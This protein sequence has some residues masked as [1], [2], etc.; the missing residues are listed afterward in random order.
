MLKRLCFLIFHILVVNAANSIYPHDHW[1]YSK[2]LTESNFEE[3]LYNEIESGRTFFVRWI[4]S[5]G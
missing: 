2:H 5:Q 3:I 1:S 4:A